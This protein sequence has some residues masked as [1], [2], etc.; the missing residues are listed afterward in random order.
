M[1]KNL[2]IFNLKIHKGAGIRKKPKAFWMKL[3]NELKNKN[4]NFAD[5]LLA[6]V[7]HETPNPAQAKFNCLGKYKYKDNFHAIK[8]S[9]NET[10]FILS[11]PPVQKSLYHGPDR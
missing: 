4:I 9:W 3:K 2:K 6:L 1:P 11:I 7:L 10:V 8:S 5:P